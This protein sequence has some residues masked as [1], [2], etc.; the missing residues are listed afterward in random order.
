[1]PRLVFWNVASDAHGPIPMLQNAMGVNLVSGFS[2]NVLQIVLSGKIDPYD[3]LISVL[4]GPRYK[5]L[6]LK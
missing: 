4:N 1:M 5:D 6:I 2:P 3:A